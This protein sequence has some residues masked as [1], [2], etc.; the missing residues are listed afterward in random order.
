M[1]FFVFLQQKI[2]QLLVPVISI[3]LL[4]IIV[5]YLMGVPNLLIIVKSELVGGMWFLRT[6]FFCYFYTYVVRTIVKNNF[7][8]CIG[9]ILLALIVPHGYFL[10]FNWMLIFFLRLFSL[11]Y[12]R[13][14]FVVTVVSLLV[15]LMCNHEAPQLLTYEVLFRYPQQLLLLYII[16]LSGSLSL[17]GCTYYVCKWI[18]YDSVIINFFAKVGTYPLGIYGLQAIVL[19]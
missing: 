11:Q 7:L 17:M 8:A 3:T 4:T 15:F 2:I 10:Q 5:C 18:R 9:S 12:E 1:H 19:Q 13:F 6:L 14:R 16:G